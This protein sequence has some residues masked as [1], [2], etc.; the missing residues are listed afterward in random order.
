MIITSINEWFQQLRKGID[1]TLNERNNMNS[2]IIGYYPYPQILAFSSFRIF[3]YVNKIPNSLSCEA[4]M[5]TMNMIQLFLIIVIKN[6][7]EQSVCGSIGDMVA[8]SSF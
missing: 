7:T 6:W 8:F 4:P 1:D 2:R 3:W 5:V